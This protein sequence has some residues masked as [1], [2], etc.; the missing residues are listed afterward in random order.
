MPYRYA[1]DPVGPR[2]ALGPQ[3]GAVTLLRFL[4]GAFDDADLVDDVASLGVYN[5]RDVCGNQWPDWRCAGSLHAEGRAG[6]AKVPVDRRRWPDGHPEGHRI[7][8]FLVDAADLLGVQ[9]VIWARRRWDSRRRTW[10]AYRGRSDHLDH[11][12]F[13]LCRAAALRLTTTDVHAA[14]QELDDMFT[15]DDR[16]KL[17][18]LHAALAELHRPNHQNIRRIRRMVRVG[19]HALGVPKDWLDRAENLDQELAG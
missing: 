2:P 12:H 19:L 14:Y 9:E 7:A 4:V 10:V 8:G 17:D 3:R 5:P 18:D 1:Y 6:D 11:V 16:K 13:G 15:T